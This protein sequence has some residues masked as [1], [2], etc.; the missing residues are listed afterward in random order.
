[1]IREADTMDPV[2]VLAF[3]TYIRDCISRLKEPEDYHYLV[4]D[5]GLMTTLSTVLDADPSSHPLIKPMQVIISIPI[6]IYIL[7]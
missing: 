4:I 7:A 6:N 2:N 5:N 3:L 1:M